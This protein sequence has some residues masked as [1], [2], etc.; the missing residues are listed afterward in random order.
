MLSPKFKEISTKNSSSIQENWLGEKEE[1]DSDD[2]EDK[3][4]EPSS[5]STMEL[6]KPPCLGQSE[7]VSAAAAADD[8]DGFRTPTSLEHKIPVVTQCPPAPKKRRP[9]PSKLKVKL[10]PMKRRTC[11]NLSVLFPPTILDDDID[12]MM[13]RVRIDHD[14]E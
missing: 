13:E 9:N 3:R 12:R 7:L 2:K 14:S 4:A 8:N 1:V 5:V 6:D 11:F 10:S